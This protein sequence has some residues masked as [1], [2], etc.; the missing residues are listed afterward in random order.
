MDAEKEVS[1]PTAQEKRQRRGRS[2]LVWGV[3]GFVVLQL[4]L[5]TY[6][7]LGG[8]GLRDPDYAY[9][10]GRLRQRTA[11]R[12]ARPLTIV[13]VGSSRTAF[14]LRARGLE[15][16]L[17]DTAGRPVAIFNFGLYGAGSVT[18]LITLQRLLDDGIRPDI[19]LIEVLPALL[20]DQ[21]PAGEVRRLPLDRLRPEEL[22]L[23]ERFGRQADDIQAARRDDLLPF[24]A[25][26]FALL[27]RV[28]PVLLPFQL[29]LDGFRSVDGSGYSQPPKLSTT[30]ERR[31]AAT[32]GT[33]DQ[34]YAM[35]QNFRFSPGSCEALHELLDRCRQEKI[36]AALV[37][38]PEGSEFRS[39]YPPR[40]RAEIDRYLVDSSHSY[41]VPLV[42][43]RE[44]IADDL[45]SD[46]HHL[47]PEG[48]TAF[49]E[50]FV[51]EVLPPIIRR[52]TPSQAAGLSGT[53]PAPV[54]Q[55]QP[56]AGPL[57]PSQ[58]FGDGE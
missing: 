23:A 56:G 6:L 35:L 58:P 33:R 32:Q 24:Y 38:M 9:K 7:R 51:R 8:M 29:R 5:F 1:V 34:F 46:S 44:W 42:D 39:W 55:G 25:H 31:R 18:E 43:A 17:T 13:M 27:S 37:L 10:A 48:A 45:F 22:A 50:R 47:L 12:Q 28:M 4:G 3:A 21:P 19:L 14:G 36:P 30:P 11:D 54:N 15:D 53:Q 49:S 57:R 26:R 2:S 52:A 16:E 41:G 20:S 40:V